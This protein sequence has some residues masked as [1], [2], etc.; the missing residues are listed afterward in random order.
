MDFEGTS[1]PQA[2]GLALFAIFVVQLGIYLAHYY[3]LAN[4]PT[5]ARFFTT[6]ILGQFALLLEL[7]SILHKS[8]QRSLVVVAL[9][10]WVFIFHRANR[11][12]SSTSSR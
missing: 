4:H 5:Q 2:I 1:I 8:K 6:D 10:L 9:L 3:G 7:I 11:N 12:A